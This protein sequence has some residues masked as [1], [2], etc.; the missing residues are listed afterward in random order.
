MGSLSF[1]G[2]TREFPVLLGMAPK[3]PSEANGCFYVAFNGF[4][5]ELQAQLG[6]A[7]EPDMQHRLETSGWVWVLESESLTA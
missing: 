2:A 4:W 5:S 7:V 6:D 3:C 1:L